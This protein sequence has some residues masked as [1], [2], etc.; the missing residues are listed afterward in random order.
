MSK[1]EQFLKE[2]KLTPKQARSS[3]FSRNSYRKNSRRRNEINNSRRREDAIRKEIIQY[4]IQR[5]TE[6]T[7]RQ[8]EEIE[9]GAESD[10]T[11]KVNKQ[12]KDQAN[13]QEAINNMI[14]EDTYI[15]NDNGERIP[16]LE[17]DLGCNEVDDNEEE[18]DNENNEICKAKFIT[19]ASPNNIQQLSPGGFTEADHTNAQKN[20][21]DNPLRERLTNL[22]D[23]QIRRIGGRRSSRSTDTIQSRIFNTVHGLFGEGK[24]GGERKNDTLFKG[25]NNPDDVITIYKTGNLIDR[26]ENS[27]NEYVYEDNTPITLSRSDIL[28]ILLYGVEKE[29]RRG[30]QFRYKVEYP[31]PKLKRVV[32]GENNTDKFEKTITC[33]TETSLRCSFFNDL[34]TLYGHLNHREDLIRSVIL[35]FDTHHDFKEDRYPTAENVWNAAF[36]VNGQ[37]ETFITWYVKKFFTPIFNP[38]NP[39]QLYSFSDEAITLAGTIQPTP[40]KIILG[41]VIIFSNTYTNAAT[42]IRDTTAIPTLL[43]KISTT[44]LQNRKF[45]KSMLLHYIVHNF[46][47]TPQGVPPLYLPPNYST[48]L[49]RDILYVHAD[50][51]YNLLTGILDDA[52]KINVSNDTDAIKLKKFKGLAPKLKQ[53]NNFFRGG[54]GNDYIEDINTFQRIQQIQQHQGQNIY[55]YIQGVINHMKLLDNALTFTFT[56]TLPSFTSNPEKYVR[57]AGKSDYPLGDNLQYVPAALFDG[58]PG[59]TKEPEYDNNTDY[60]RFIEQRGAADYDYN[61]NEEFETTTSRIEHLGNKYKYRRGGCNLEVGQ[62]N[63]DNNVLAKADI[64]CRKGEFRYP[65][66]DEIKLENKRKAYVKGYLTRKLDPIVPDNEFILKMYEVLS[67]FVPGDGNQFAIDNTY[68]LTLPT[69]FNNIKNGPSVQDLVFLTILYRL[70]SIN[71]NNNPTRDISLQLID[72]IVNLKRVGDYGQVMDAKRANLPFFTIDSMESLM[73]IIEKVSCYIDFN[74]GVIIYDNGINQNEVQVT[75]DFIRS[76][77]GRG[78]TFNLSRFQ[79]QVPPGYGRRT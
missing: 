14:T 46:A 68:T 21:F 9:K 48:I 45:E 70:N 33:Y 12:L 35:W 10:T 25:Q 5:E 47:V 2:L 78:N 58:N 71:T 69:Y 29:V 1:L 15:I 54:E 65:T 6:E 36:T 43:Y 32:I 16:A 72:N 31:K 34:T 4:I 77:S 27:F 17:L 22:L 60:D 3:P 23:T 42:G 39:N 19:S 30:E 73:C 53:L 66:P 44:H 76:K 57:D 52:G 50:T 64:R 11:E 40:E 67:K 55:Q 74:Q 41:P 49:L 79:S 7:R 37:R 18:G 26:I 13:E 56:Q 61:N 28:I 8:A 51:Y 63:Q 59:N 24:L 20:V 38:N 75:S 62:I